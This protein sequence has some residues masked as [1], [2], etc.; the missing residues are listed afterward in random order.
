MEISGS[1]SCLNTSNWLPLQNNEDSGH[2]CHFHAGDLNS[3]G[4]VKHI[5]KAERNPRNVIA[6]SCQSPA[7]IAEVIQQ[8]HT[9]FIICQSPTVSEVVHSMAGQIYIVQEF[10]SSMW[11]QC[12]NTKTFVCLTTPLNS[13]IIKIFLSLALIWII[14]Q[15]LSIYI[16]HD[17]QPSQEQIKSF[18]LEHHNSI[19]NTL[20][21]TLRQLSCFNSLFA[22]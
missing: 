6:R 11:R 2:S 22:Y 4:K 14:L 3:L 7:V 9:S 1:T 13:V 8:R 16:Y 17:A 5:S 20:L 18:N 21:S 12:S 15:V 10:T 19:T